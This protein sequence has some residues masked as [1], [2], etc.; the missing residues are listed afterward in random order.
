MALRENF[1]NTGQLISSHWIK[2][3]DRGSPGESGRF[4]ELKL[5]GGVS[6][7]RLGE[8][9]LRDSFGQEEVRYV[10][11][12]EGRRNSIRCGKTGAQVGFKWFE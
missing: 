11:T 8:I 5:I 12:G 4:R 2:P 1:A 3:I 6:S 9:P 10:M 7:F